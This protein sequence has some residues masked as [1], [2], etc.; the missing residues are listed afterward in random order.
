MTRDVDTGP[1]DVVSLAADGSGVERC[2]QPH[3]PLVLGVV[4]TAP[5]MLLGAAAIQFER[6][7]GEQPIALA[8]RVPCK[9]CAENG[10]IRKGNLLVPASLPG[11]AMRA[12]D[13][14]TGCTIGKA[15]ADFD[16]DTGLIDVFVFLR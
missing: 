13:N 14:P 12:G 2:R 6:N 4:S 10:P 5:G 3:D 11:H 1:G 8:G 7:P 16:G 15:L 9:V